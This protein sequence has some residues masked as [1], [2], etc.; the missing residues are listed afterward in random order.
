MTGKVVQLVRVDD[1]GDGPYE[2][3]RLHDDGTM[4]LARIAFKGDNL[5][6]EVYPMTEEFKG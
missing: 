2:L 4:S 5:V 6:A 3:I 1:G